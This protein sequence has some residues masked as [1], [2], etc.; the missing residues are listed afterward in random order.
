[1]KKYGEFYTNIEKAV[2]FFKKFDPEETIRVIS[3]LDA[4]GI[5]A[6]AILINVL[7]QENKK[8]SISILPQLNKKKID[9]F[10]E[11]PY[12]NFIFTD[13]G[14]G[15]LKN[16]KKGLKEKNILILDHHEPEEPVS[17]KNI[18]HINPHLNDI[19]G[20]KE[21]SGAG[22]V[23]LFAQSLD[24][25]YKELAHIAVIGALGDIQ[26]KG[27]FLPL[28]KS[29]LDTAIEKNNIEVKKGLRLFGTQTKPI[30]KILEYSTDPIIPGV[31]GS[32][33]RA[34][35]FLE[36]IGI[37]PK[38]GKGW[39]KIID[40]NKEEMNRLI[41]GIVMKRVKEG[42][43]EDVLGNIYIL[44]KEKQGTPLKDARE[45]A[46][47]LNA[48]GR[49]DK[50]S[51]GIGACIGIS[52][53]KSRAMKTLSEYKKEIVRAIRWFEQNKKYADII[54]K[55][56]YMILNAKHNILSTVA[57][58]LASILSKSNE[59]TEGTYIMSMARAPDLS[60]KVSLRV[61]GAKKDI[62]LR[63]VVKKIVDSDSLEGCE[64]GG[65]ACAAGAIIPTEKEK[66]FIK[67][68]QEILDKL[69][70]EESIS[71]S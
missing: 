7:N 44:K 29:I 34:I 33:T 39:K 6:C 22:V 59:Y 71:I 53:D 60:T 20:S 27:E 61:A 62:D 69:S 30:H 15:Q 57:G 11:E 32:E 68:S 47:L 40:L 28:N 48:C 52:S 42:D 23:Y 2:A 16:I 14:S 36:Q 45:F 46:T 26:E 31:S 54:R 9:E 37:D 51:F 49:M 70:L 17:E 3:H 63:E 35:Q 18:M 12:K 10:A 25:K 8:Y 21:I 4:D 43:P 50:A 19:D 58:T 64:A 67:K 65:H 38:K 5:S 41:T 1:M 56:K 13:L 66:E 55:E 24:E